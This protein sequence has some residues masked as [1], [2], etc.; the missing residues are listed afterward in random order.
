MLPTLKL[1]GDY[2]A[3]V[4]ISAAE[5]IR[6]T[7]RLAAFEDFTGGSQG[8]FG[9]DYQGPFMDLSFFGDGQLRPAAVEL[10]RRAAGARA[11]ESW[12][13]WSPSP[14]SWASS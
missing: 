12:G 1:R 7:G 10:P 9:K 8:I 2:L 3:I 11:C 13:C 6:Y 5:I 4:T 14:R